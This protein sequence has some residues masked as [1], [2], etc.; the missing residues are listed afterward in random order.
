MAEIRHHFLIVSEPR[1]E[2]Y[3]Q[4]LHLLK[5]FASAILFVIR[6]EMPLSIG[7]TFFLQRIEKHLIRREERSSWPG[8]ELFGHTAS[9]LVYKYDSEVVSE[10]LSHSSGLYDWIQPELPEDLCILREGEK[11][12]LTTVS[13]EKFSYLVVRPSEE[14]LVRQLASIG[15]KMRQW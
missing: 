14:E 11:E 4:L 2:A 10:I 8:T 3:V 7:A 12:L 9:V 1:G 5:P 13:H 6:H 15:I